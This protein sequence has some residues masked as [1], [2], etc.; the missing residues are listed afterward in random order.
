MANIAQ[1][2][3]LQ[4]KYDAALTDKVIEFD[5]VIPDGGSPPRGRWSAEELKAGKHIDAYEKLPHPK[6]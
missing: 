4:Q 5:E 2:R 1:E 3:K 6:E